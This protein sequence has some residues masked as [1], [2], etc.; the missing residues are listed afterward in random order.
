M[1]GVI[2]PIATAARIERAAQLNTATKAG[3]IVAAYKVLQELRALPI[4]AAR[5]VILEAG[6]SLTHTRSAREFW[7]IVQGDVAKAARGKVDGWGVRD[8]GAAR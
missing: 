3:D 5:A 4:D 7:T 8:L 1:S 6:H 2:E